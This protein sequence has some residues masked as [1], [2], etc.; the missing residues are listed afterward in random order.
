M[1]AS[2]DGIDLAKLADEEIKGEEIGYPEYGLVENPFPVSAIATKT[3]LFVDTGSKFRLSTFEEIGRRIVHTARTGRYRGMVILGDFGLGKTHTLY[4]FMEMINKQL[5][6]KKGVKSLAIYISSP[7][8]SLY[9]FLS[10]FLQE[11]DIE[12]ILSLTYMADKEAIVDLVAD[13]LQRLLDEQKKSYWAQ[14]FTPALEQQIKTQFQKLKELKSGGPDLDALRTTS[15]SISLLIAPPYLS[16]A[17]PTE[18]AI[19]RELSKKLLDSQ[20]ITLEDFAFCLSIL[21]VASNQEHRRIAAKYIMGQKLLAGEVK[22]LGL[23]SNQLSATDVS[24][25]VFPDLL[26]ILHNTGEQFNMIFVFVDEFEK[27]VMGIKGSKRFEFLEDLRNLIDYN[28]TQFS[29]ILG[30]SAEAYETIK[31]TSPAF[32]DRNRDLI[33]LPTL[34]GIEEVRNLI[35]PYLREKRTADF[36]G[37]SVH[38][39]SEEALSIILDQEKG[40][41]RY[42]LEACHKLLNYGLAEK[43]KTIGKNLV[44]NWYGIKE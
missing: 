24:K 43:S 42:I 13:S 30:C 38:P 33:E 28:L 22:W 16:Y 26:K 25:R 21:L 23:T 32:A 39:F 15:Q 10:S 12:Y 4:Y 8:S 9:D 34:Q 40:S 7:G 27:I 3:R 11:I 37:D 31:S 14:H 2:N 44:N 29:L 36:H 18:L 17:S 19:C 1:N 35:E 41:P 20:M 5:G 6:D